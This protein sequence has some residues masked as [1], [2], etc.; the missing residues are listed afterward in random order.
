ML[1]EAQQVLKQYFGYENFRNGQAEIISNILS[2]RDTAGIMPTGGGKSI[3]YQIPALLLDGVTLVISPLI[4]LMKDQVDSL[5]FQG[6]PATFINSTL[7]NAET[8]A[9]MEEVAMGE[10]KLLYIAPER[11]E[12]SRFVDYLNTLNI[13]LVAVDEAHCLSEW[14]HD[15]RPSYLGIYGAVKRLSSNPVMLALTAT[16]TPQ[17]QTD[18][19][20]HL[21]IPSE[22]KVLT[23][24]QRN[25]LYFNVLKGED[26]KRWVGDYIQRNK[27]QSGIIYCATRKEVE[28]VHDHLVKKG[29]SAGKYHGGLSDS[30]RLEQQEAFLNDSIMVMVAT[31]A[32][33]MGINKSNVRYVIHY[34]IPKNMEAYYQEA[35]RAGRDGVESECILLFSPQDIQTQRYIIEQ[36]VMNQDLHQNELQKLRDMVDFVHTE[37]CLQQYILSYFGDETDE[38]CGHCSNCLDDRETEDVTVKAQMVLSCMKRMNERF[39]TTLISAVLTGSKGKK[40]KD[41]GFDRLSTYGLLKDESQKEVGLFIDYLIAE[42]IIDVE[43]GGY[44]TLRVSKKGKEVLVGERKVS[45]K[46]QEDAAP[47]LSNEDELFHTLRTLRKSIAE[48]EGVPPFVIFS[49]KTLHDMCLKQ[50]GDEA[51]FLNVSGVGESKLERYGELFMNKISTFLKENEEYSR[52]VEEREPGSV[53]PR[54]QRGKTDEPSH[55][56]TFQLYNENKSM[57][58]IASIRNMSVAT[59]ENHIIRS[60]EEGLADDWTIFFNEDEEDLLKEAVEK[61]GETPLKPIKEELPEDISYFQI[62]GYLAKRRVVHD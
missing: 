62:K 50:P 14:G 40:I 52:K 47:V 31:N 30:L 26:R 28:R 21:H 8:E 12:S 20:S 25:N 7:S 42:G 32:F 6:I 38:E 51:E 59:I 48:E 39:G 46:K 58:E 19:L 35:G 16:A 11:L 36:N 45:R 17:V 23:G 9:R 4:S 41:F 61:V 34:Q 2:G 49:D 56:I 55:H 27:Q 29:L 37:S 57:K 24:F 3:C 5:T 44:P 53:S 33:G 22:N 13:P 15:F 54:K 43:G 60:Y 10:Y 18:I 1:N